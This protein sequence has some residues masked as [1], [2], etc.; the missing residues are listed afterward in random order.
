MVGFAFTLADCLPISYRFRTTLE[1]V[2]DLNDV[3]AADVNAQVDTAL[4]DINLDHLIK[5]AKD[6][7]W[8]T[9][10]TKESVIDLLTSKSTA[11]TFDRLSDS[12]ESIRDR[13]DLAWLTG[14]AAAADTLTFPASV[15]KIVGGT[16]TGDHT[17]LTL[18]NGSYCSLVETTTTTFL[19]L[20][21][22]FAAPAGNDASALRVWGYY[23]GG[24][25]HYIRVQAL[26]QTGG[27]IYEDVGTMPTAGIVTAY[28]FALAPNHI[29]ADGSVAVK[30]LHNASAS[31]IGSHVLYLDKVEVLTNT[32]TAAV[33]DVNVVSMADGVITPGAIA[34]G[35]IDADAIAANA[36]G[37]SE[38]ATDAV[39]EIA[40]AINGATTTADHTEL[41]RHL[42]LIEQLV[43]QHGHRPR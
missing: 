32:A 38:L 5:V 25:S 40:N 36:I 6:T 14:S 18:V 16:L 17:N 24:A 41:L 22:A 4:S 39:T 34:T 35:A 19:E 27:T 31:G 1:L 33:T 9:T 20:N 42:R 37:A 10:V 11:Q 3:S 29:K 30:F 7:D 23:A 21:V 26:D 12:L 43:R 8:A 28:L 13:G 2:S 15:T